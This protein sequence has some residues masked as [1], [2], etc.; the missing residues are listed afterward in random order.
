MTNTDLFKG[1]GKFHSICISVKQLDSN[2]IH[3][4]AAPLTDVAGALIDALARQTLA[5]KIA[6]S[7]VHLQIYIDIVVTKHQ[8]LQAAFSKCV[9]LATFSF[10]P[11]ADVL[12]NSM[13]VARFE[14]QLDNL[15]DVATA[16][17]QMQQTEGRVSVFVRCLFF[18]RE[19]QALPLYTQSDQIAGHI[20]QL[21]TPLA[22]ARDQKNSRYKHAVTMDDLHALQEAIGITIDIAM[23]RYPTS[24]T[25]AIYA[26]LAT[27][28]KRTAAS[29]HDFEQLT[30]E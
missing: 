25:R 24:E 22:V 8:I 18:T 29:N 16:Y 30:R 9:S 1:I 28:M 5:T 4:L 7:V 17:L 2:D 26:R 23:R 6:N 11:G 27:N 10:R 14:T 20:A 3:E 19:I 21:H 13:S 15:V 12:T